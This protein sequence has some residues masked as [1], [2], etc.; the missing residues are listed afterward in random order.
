[1]GERFILVI[2]PNMSPFVESR[3]DLYD[4]YQL[5]IL[6]NLFYVMPNTPIGSM[7]MNI[8]VVNWIYIV[9]F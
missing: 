5:M 2:K 4:R 8:M 9:T 7:H 3:R 6:Q 1:M